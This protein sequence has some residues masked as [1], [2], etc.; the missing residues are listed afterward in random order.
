VRAVRKRQE[1]DLASGHAVVRD[2]LERRPLPEVRVCDRDRLAGQR[3]AACH[4]L[5]HLGMPTEQA[6]QLAAGIATGAD[7]ADLH[8]RPFARATA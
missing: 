5:G 3:L 8:Y 2:E 6:K 1:H 7:D 4:D